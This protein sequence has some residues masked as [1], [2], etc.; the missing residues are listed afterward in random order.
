[1]RDVRR[2]FTNFCFGF[3][4]SSLWAQYLVHRTQALLTLSIIM[5][6]LTLCEVIIAAID[7]ADRDSE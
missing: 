1:M 7:E 2:I 4:L 3:A 6:V 5:S